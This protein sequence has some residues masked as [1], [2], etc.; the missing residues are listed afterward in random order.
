[1]RINIFAALCAALAAAC[2]PTVPEN[3]ISDECLAAVQVE[4]RG[5]SA[6][7]FE[8]CREE[9]TEIDTDT[10]PD[11]DMVDTAP[12][13]TG[14]PWGDT[15][16]EPADEPCGPTLGIHLTDRAIEVEDDLIADIAIPGLIKRST[17]AFETHVNLRNKLGCGKTQLIG[18]RVTVSESSIEESV[19]AGIK[20]AMEGTCVRIFNA[21]NGQMMHEAC[22]QGGAHDLFDVDSFT[23][24]VQGYAWFSAYTGTGFSELNIEGS[25][26]HNLRIEVDAVQ[27]FPVDTSPRFRVSLEYKAQ[28]I[29]ASGLAVVNMEDKSNE[30]SVFFEP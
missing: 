28:A 9:A 10:A 25:N 15:D 13:D 6:E 29:T 5:F 30:S 1:M 2:G 21:D 14:F 8:D 23:S 4:G 18:V 20:A 19:A 17:S 22:Y 27:A 3:I 26:V 24:S 12:L 16:V 7:F 11:P